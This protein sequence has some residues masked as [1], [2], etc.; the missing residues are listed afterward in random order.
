MVVNMMM[1]ACMKTVSLLS[2]GCWEA[3][4]NIGWLSIDAAA[5]ATVLIKAWLTWEF[6]L[7]VS[8]CNYCYDTHTIILIVI[9]SKWV[10]WAMKRGRANNTPA[11]C[12][13]LHI[14]GHLLQKTNKKYEINTRSHVHMPIYAHVPYMPIYVQCM[15][16]QLLIK[17]HANKQT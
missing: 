3:W 15:P 9:S 12:S 1:C 17:M 14:F 4:P 5:A 11:F 8:S 6:M 7:K 13:H 16:L 2:P 10:R